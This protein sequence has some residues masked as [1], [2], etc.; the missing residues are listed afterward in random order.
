M[1]ASKSRVRE[2]LRLAQNASS[3]DEMTK[4]V[5]IILTEERGLFRAP[6]WNRFI[7]KDKRLKLVVAGIRF[8]VES[9]VGKKQK[10]FG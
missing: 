9:G 8:A 3:I 6:I 2:L 4:Y 7:V 1:R 10:R 5:S